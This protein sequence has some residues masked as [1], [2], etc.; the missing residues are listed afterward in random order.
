MADAVPAMTQAEPQ[1][2][3]NTAKE[4]R[5]SIPEKEVVPAP[6]R[7]VIERVRKGRKPRPF[8]PNHIEKA[9][10]AAKKAPVK[11][12]KKATPKV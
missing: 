11:T 4:V 5:L 10:A 1:E 6:E 12:T 3:R 2:P 9:A 8:V 7:P